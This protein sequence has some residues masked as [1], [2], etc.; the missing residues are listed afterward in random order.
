VWRNGLGTTYTQDDY[1]TW[2]IH[3]G[4]TV[5]SGSAARSFDS[6]VP[7]PTTL[8][9]LLPILAGFFRKR[10]IRHSL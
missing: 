1:D 3:F 2:R 5:G 7:E 10:R 4:Q 6:A 8:T 9:T